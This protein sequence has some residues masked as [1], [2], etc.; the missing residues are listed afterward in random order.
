M[1]RSKIFKKLCRG[2]FLVEVS[3]TL[4]IAGTMLFAF[5]SSFSYS[6][7]GIKKVRQLNAV[8]SL[9]RNQMFSLINEFRESGNTS[10][11]SGIVYYG[12]YTYE[13]ESSIYQV[14][15]TD[16]MLYIINLNFSDADNVIFETSTF[17]KADQE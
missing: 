3:V 13:W 4:L 16:E 7:K 5:M 12:G 17:I 1:R 10:P 15:D 11:K 14:E 8:E 6:L 2:F 9:C